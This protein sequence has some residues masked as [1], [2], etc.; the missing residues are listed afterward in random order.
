MRMQIGDPS[1]KSLQLKVE[2]GGIYSDHTGGKTTIADI[3]SAANGVQFL[4]IGEN[5][6]NPEHHQFQ[7]DVIDALVKS[8]RNVIVGMEMFQRRN[9]TAL[10]RWTLN[11]TSQDEFITES[12]WKNVWGFDYGLYKPIFDV[13]RANRL[14]LV[15]LNI[16]RDWVRKVSKDGAKAL[17]AEDRGSMPELDLTNLEHRALIKAM[18]GDMP[19]HAVGDGTFAGQILWDTAMADTALTYWERMPRSPQWIFVV[20]AGSGHIMYD[21][22]IPYRLGQRASYKRESIV[23]LE[24][25]ETVSRSIGDFV[26]CTKTYTRPDEPQTTPKRGK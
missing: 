16:P 15:G 1:R 21:L 22:G 10:F 8:G 23:C 11:K 6:D 5:H 2:P 3:V 7:A 12:D 14:P 9:Q 24:G 13:V 26:Y 17:T 4:F 25:P 18:I 19:G 20:L